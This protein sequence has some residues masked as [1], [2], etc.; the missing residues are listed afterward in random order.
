MVRLPNGFEPTIGALIAFVK[1]KGGAAIHQPAH[2]SGAT[3]GC[4]TL[5]HL[6]Q[7]PLAV[8]SP[9]AT[10][11]E[12]GVQRAKRPA[13]ITYRPESCRYPRTTRACSKHALLMQS[14]RPM[15]SSVADG[16]QCSFSAS[17]R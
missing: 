14:K 1:E 3:A 5:H 17:A 8:L 13:A 2:S 7:Y 9:L 15:T 6:K 16:R 4:N 12:I 10:H 11:M